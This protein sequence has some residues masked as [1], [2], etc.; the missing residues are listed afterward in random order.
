[1]ADRYFPISNLN[2]AASVDCDHNY[3]TDLANL[4]IDIY[5]WNEGTGLLTYLDETT[6]PKLSEIA[7]I[8]KVGDT[9]KQITVTNNSLAQVDLALVLSQEILRLSEGDIKDIDIVSVAPE[10]GQSL[11]FE[12]SSSKFKPGA[13]GDSSFKLQKLTGTVLTIKKGYMGLSDGSEIYSSVDLTPDL[14]T[15]IPGANADYYGYF[16]RYLFP[17]YTTVNGRKLIAMTTAQLVFSTTTPDLIDRSRYVAIGKVQKAAGVFTNIETLAMRKH[18]VALG[19]DSSLV[20]SLEYTAIGAVG[21]A[22]QLNSGHQ[23]ATSSFPA[24]ALGANLSWYGL[25][26]LTDG[27]GNARTLVNTPSTPL[28]GAD[29]FGNANSVYNFGGSHYL[30]SPDLLFDPGNA[31]FCFGAWFKPSAW[32]GVFQSFV[33]Q[34]ETSKASFFVLIDSGNLNV[35]GYATGVTAIP[36]ISYNVSALTGYH[37][38]CVRYTASGYL[39]E[40]FIDGIKV[41]SGSTGVAIQSVGANRRLNIGSYNNGAGIFYTGVVDEFFFD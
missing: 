12:S 6:T 26:A 25:N 29:I 15:F 4:H 9:K 3:N 30:S 41:A 14:A 17:D 8:A 40:L 27:S 5:G 37:H 31:N 11:V 22:G 32:S 19:A 34:Y 33:S 28:T 10:D 20:D 38:V 35:S 39:F 16:D 13:S 1:M 2:A 21:D 18:D 7:V 24:A 36:V 23:L